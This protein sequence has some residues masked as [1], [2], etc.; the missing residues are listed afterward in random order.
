MNAP[1]MF[2]FLLLGLFLNVGCTEST[3]QSVQTTPVEDL[4]FDSLK[5][6]EFDVEKVEHEDGRMTI[7]FQL[8]RHAVQ[9]VAVIVENCLYLSPEHSINDITELE[10][11]YL[12]RGIFAR[13]PI[14]DNS[15]AFTSNELACYHAAMHDLLSEINADDVGAWTWCVEEARRAGDSDYNL[16]GE[17]LSLLRGWFLSN[18]VKYPD[19][20]QNSALILSTQDQ[21]VVLRNAI[22]EYL[23]M[24]KS[25]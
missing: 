15:N 22:V 12:D 5:R 7:T 25:C 9:D 1:M 24:E 21:K 14:Y 2:R 4:V 11:R 18:G 23:Q 16:N 13:T 8:Y 3:N 17:G 6:M 10:A 19:A 20:L